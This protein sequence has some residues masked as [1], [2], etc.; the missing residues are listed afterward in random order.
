MSQR[1]QW[2]V[3]FFVLSPLL[4]L[5]AT[6]FLLDRGGLAILSSAYPL[7]HAPE[8]LE[9]NE[10]HHWTSR[11]HFSVLKCRRICD[12]GTPYDMGREVKLALMSS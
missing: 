12:T 4:R 1:V 9:R 2:C 7:E 3:V 6:F 8:V 11:T 5:L 10:A